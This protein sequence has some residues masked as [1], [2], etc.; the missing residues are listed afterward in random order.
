MYVSDQFRTYP[1]HSLRMASMRS[2]AKSRLFRF[3]RTADAHGAH[4]DGPE[5][6]VRSAVRALARRGRT[7]RKG[8]ALGGR[9][10]G[11][12]G[13]EQRPAQPDRHGTR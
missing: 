4:A 12:G 8:D 1:N 2:P 13:F 9:L 7:A 5:A 11:L 3:F 6:P 10:G